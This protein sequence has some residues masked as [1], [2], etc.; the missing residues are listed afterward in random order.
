LAARF[1][2]NKL[3]F[4]ID[5]E[6]AKQD[7]I[8]PVGNQGPFTGLNGGFNSPFRDTSAFGKLD[9][10]IADNAHMFYR[11]SYEQNR[12]VRGFIQNSFPAFCQREQY[13]GSCY[14]PGFQ[15]REFYPMR[16]VSVYQVSAMELLTQP[17]RGYSIRPRPSAS[18]SGSDPFC[19]TGGADAFC[20]GPNLLAPQKTFQQNTQAKYDGSKTI[21]AHILRY[22]FGFNH[23]QGGGFAKFFALAPTVNADVIDFN[24]AVQPF[25]GGAGNR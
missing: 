12:N 23:I 7:F 24:P 16:C 14:R 1:L 6:R 21:H 17:R 20:S 11:F 18:A 3:F 5:G 22:G 19:L 25:A 2:R 15:Y 4:F 10:R 13:P 9:W 8:N